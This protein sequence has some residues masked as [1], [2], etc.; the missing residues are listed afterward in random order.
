[1]PHLECNVWLC[2]ML[3][4]ADQLWLFNTL[5]PSERDPISYFYRLEGREQS[6]PWARRKNGVENTV[7]K[8]PYFTLALQCLHG[9]PQEVSTCPTCQLQSELS[10]EPKDHYLNME[11]RGQ[12]H[13]DVKCREQ[14]G[15]F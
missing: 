6:L 13:L 12:T 4:R 3:S 7:G 14:K 11:G 1:M 15:N 9:L 10:Q 8:P 5:Y 2:H